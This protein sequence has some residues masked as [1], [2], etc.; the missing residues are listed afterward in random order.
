M[1]SDADRVVGGVGERQKRSPGQRVRSP[2]RPAPGCE[3]GRANSPTGT[4]LRPT[5]NGPGDRWPSVQRGAL[6]RLKRASIR[7]LWGHGNGRVRSDG[8]LLRKRRAPGLKRTVSATAA[9]NFHK[10]RTESPGKW[11]RKSA[12][13]GNIWGR[14]T[15]SRVW[16]AEGDDGAG[17]GGRAGVGRRDCEGNGGREGGGSRVE[18]AGRGVQERCTVCVGAGGAGART[19]SAGVAVRGQPRKHNGQA[20]IGEQASAGH[21]PGM[22]GIFSKEVNSHPRPAHGGVVGKQETLA[23]PPWRLQAAMPSVRL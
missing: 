10:A 5:R 4:R 16:E 3:G 17:N 19:G 1:C 8:A 11:G 21:R 6:I 2:P 9:H 18:N 12:S 20:S 7:K 15:R 14:A 22:E 23:P 13:V